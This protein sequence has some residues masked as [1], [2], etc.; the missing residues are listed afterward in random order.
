LK[1]GCLFLFGLMAAV[2]PAQTVSVSSLLDEMPNLAWLAARPKP[3]FRAAQASS[4]DRA[5]TSPKDD[6]T[7]FANG[8]LG[9][10]VRIEEANGR[11]EY[12][13]ADLVGPG[14]V[15]RV[16]SAN[17]LGTIRFYFDGE[18]K[19]RLEE[20]MA[21]L[22][23]GNVNP[24]GD[25]L[26]YMAAQGANLYFPFPYAKSLK[27][28]VENDKPEWPSLYYH[29]GYR[30]YDKGTKV[31]T[32]SP[33]DLPAGRISVIRSELASGGLKVSPKNTQTVN[34]KPMAGKTFT[35]TLTAKSGGVLQMLKVKI[36]FPL[37]QFIK[38]PDW[39]DPH[40][41]HNVLRNTI[42]RI[43]CDGER[44]VEVPLG[45]FFATAPGINEANSLPISVTKDG[46]M[47]C[48]WPM[49]FLKQMDIS[50]VPPKGID[51]PMQVTFAWSDRKF[52]PD[53]YYFRAI[54]NVDIGNTRPMRDMEFLKAEGEGTFVG[55]HLH[56][57]NPTP[58]WWGEGD[59]KIYVDNEAFPSTFGTGTEDYYGYAWCS[60]KLFTKPYHGQAR[61]DGPGNFG[62]TS[63]RRFQTFDPITFTKSFRFDM[64]MWHWQQVNARFARVTYWYSRPGSGP[65]PTGIKQSD[66]LLVETLPPAPVKGATEAESLKYAMT[67]GTV[68]IQSGFWELSGDKQLWWLDPKEGDKLTVRVPVK[69]A[70]KYEVFAH[71]G[72]AK[73]YGIHS[74]R[75]LDS[76]G[77]ELLPAKQFDFYGEGVAWKKLSLGTTDL[78]AG[79]FV[80]EVVSKGHNPKAEPRHML[81]LDYL[82]LERK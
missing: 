57:T 1:R 23:S 14:A 52:T 70:G 39:T 64:E 56:V 33:N 45:D 12:V 48:Y 53:T 49:P 2:A 51:L 59:E 66:L 11:K 58:A 5:S 9:K 55:G 32:Y 30:T 28:T 20:K 47:T 38:A 31:D 4:Y 22:L 80:L 18:T 60:P 68:E 6:K 24:F 10:Y 76:T 13:M 65:K 61:C 69:T 3:Y 19:P 26:A 63:V 73:D 75:V 50:I 72:H 15:V 77:K 71:L 43:T 41:P 40:V 34:V 67:G 79:E 7:W 81:G 36:P 42:L 82:M 62:Q 25:P 16:W 21:D 29:V 78:P 54:W 35:K 74:F 37:V 8:D 17:P 46:T 44:T 27:I